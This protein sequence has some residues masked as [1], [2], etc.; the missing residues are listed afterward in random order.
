MAELKVGLELSLD[1][2]VPVCIFPSCIRGFDSLR[3]L[4][5]KLYL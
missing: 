3:P 4:Q 1:L 5:F 2:S